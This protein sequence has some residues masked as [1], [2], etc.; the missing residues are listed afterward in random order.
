MVLVTPQGCAYFICA[1]GERAKR[2]DQREKFEQNGLKMPVA[3][4]GG[5]FL[6]SQGWQLDEWVNMT[7]VLKCSEESGDL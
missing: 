7:S 3:L 6:L 1:V 5:V 4:E 2:F